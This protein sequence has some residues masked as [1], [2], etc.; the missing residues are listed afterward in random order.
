MM[1]FICSFVCDNNRLK[2]RKLSASMELGP[3]ALEA[4]M[5]LWVGLPKELLREKNDDIGFTF[6][7]NSD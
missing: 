5:E 4:S 7:K 2:P 1:R 3:V 6:S